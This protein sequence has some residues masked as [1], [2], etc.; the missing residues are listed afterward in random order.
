MACLKNHQA[1][2]L[3]KH[4]AKLCFTDV[5]EDSA[6]SS[7]LCWEES[8]AE[9]PE[10]ALPEPVLPDPVPEPIPVSEPI[11]APVPVPQPVP[12]PTPL[13]ESVMAA[14][15]KGPQ[16]MLLAWGLAAQST[17]D[18]VTISR[19]SPT[20]RRLSWHDEQHG[21]NLRNLKMGVRPLLVR[22]LDGFFSLSSAGESEFR[23][24]SRRV[25]IP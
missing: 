8:E 16:R 22:G 2:S 23:T 12:T 1:S 10:P 11:T 6:V 15:L 14:G 13:E 9:L 3:T 18:K 5:E 19:M 7:I 21:T 25:G 17:G 20:L 24:L 4:Q